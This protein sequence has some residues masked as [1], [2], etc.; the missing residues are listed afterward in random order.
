MQGEIENVR[1][2]LDRHEAQI[3]TR[4]ARD[5]VDRIG[6]Q[7]EAAHAELASVTGMLQELQSHSEK[8]ASKDSAEKLKREIDALAQGSMELKSSLTGLDA[9]TRAISTQVE[10]KLDKEIGPVRRVLESLQESV[11]RLLEGLERAASKEV[12][13]R[14]QSQL[15]PVI[16]ELAA[17]WESVSRFETVISTTSQELGAQLSTEVAPIT[18]EVSSVRA[19]VERLDAQV[20]SAASRD[21]TEQLQR[22]LV[23][24]T[25]GLDELKASVAGLEEKVL[26]A[27]KEL[28]ER[29]AED[30]GR[31]NQEVTALKA[32]IGLLRSQSDAVSATASG[33]PVPKAIGSKNDYLIAM[34][35]V[36]TSSG[37]AGRRIDALAKAA[38]ISEDQAVEI[39]TSS[40]DFTLATNSK[41][42]RTARLSG[43]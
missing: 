33:T 20:G 38:G 42:Q 36:L 41:G 25:T 11:G 43:R 35:K 24:L 12:T 4:A 13:D 39:L 3:E 15:E 40:A 2:S 37:R 23:P 21:V 31:V 34:R 5:A 29:L 26:S 19:A 27:P 10:D 7:V 30:L 1:Q 18:Q 9:A 8:L 22:D 17:L 6:S 32:A 16:K 14:L 28:E